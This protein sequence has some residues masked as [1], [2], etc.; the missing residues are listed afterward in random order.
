MT[1]LVGVTLVVI[2]AVSCSGSKAPPVAQ[3]SSPSLA[4]SSSS[5]TPT[6][7]VVPDLVGKSKENAEASL[8]ALGL[9]ADTVP[10]P[11]TE[12]KP[13]T[14]V[15]QSPTAGS[16]VDPSTGSIYLFLAAAP[17]S[18]E[19]TGRI[20]A[21][22]VA[23]SLSKVSYAVLTSRDGYV[24]QNAHK[25]RF[26]LALAISVPLKTPAR[27]KLRSMKQT[28]LDNMDALQQQGFR[29][30]FIGFPDSTAVSGYG[31]AVVGYSL[32]DWKQ[33]GTYKQTE[34]LLGLITNKSIQ[35]KPV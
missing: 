28:V 31:S 27:L 5:P 1:R 33:W 25:V 35:F 13:G 9:N 19:D 8:R 15:S 2:A 23:G 17:P 26:G 20:V 30:V 11:T 21:Q 16:S 29:Y 12:A 24:L 34:I 14:V 18:P 32:S 7:V 10:T 4:L 6:T 22:E 3:K